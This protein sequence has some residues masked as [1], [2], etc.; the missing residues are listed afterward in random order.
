MEPELEREIAEYGPPLI[1]VVMMPRDTNTQGNIFGGVI[2]SYI[3][4]AGGEEAARTA[5]GRVV[6]KVVREVQF[7]A[8]VYVGDHVSFHARTERVGRTSVT[9]RVLVVANRGR[10]RDVVVKVTEA[11][12]V[13]VAVDD[14]G[15]PRPLEAP[16]ANGGLP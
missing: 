1:R 2:L 14:Q 13:M 9:V 5:R 8:P 7:I 12:L 16:P 4:F 6:T 10:S 15:R 3:D 11:E